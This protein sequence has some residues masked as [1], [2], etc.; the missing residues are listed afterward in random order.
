MLK[1]WSFLLVA[2]LALVVAMASCTAE[3]QIVE[4]TRVVTETEVV[5][6]EVPGEGSETVVEV[7]VE[8][9]REVEVVVTEV[10]TE[11]VEVE[12]SPDEEARNGGWLD[13]I[14]FVRE[15]DQNAAVARLL[16]GDIDMY[17]SG[18]TVAAAQASAASADSIQTTTQYGLYYEIFFNVGACTDET[19]LNPFTNAKIRE[20]MNWAIDRDYVADEIYGGTAVPKYTAFS[21]AGVDRAN[22]ATEIRAM[23]T[24]YAYNLEAAREVII[25]EMEG[26]GATLVDG[27]WNYNDAPVNL[28]FLIRNGGGPRTVK[29]N[30][31]A[32]QLEELGFQVERR[33]GS[34]SDLSPLW[35]QGDPTACLWHAYTGGWSQTAIARDDAGSFNQF[36]LPEGYP[37]PAWQVFDVPQEMSDIINRLVN[38]D[39]AD[40]EERAELF[41]E[42]L[43][44]TLEQSYRVWV[45]S[46]ITPIPYND[47]VQ[48]TSDLAAGIQGATLWAR[49]VRFTDEVGG[50]MTVGIE[51][52]FVEPWN[53]IGGSNWVF[54]A[55]VKNAI[56]EPA[57]YPDPNL[58]IAFPNRV[59]S[60]AIEVVEGTPIGKNEGSDWVE[61]T[62]VPEIAV[63]DDAWVAWDAENQVFLTASEVYTEPTRAV[64]KSTVT[65]PAGFDGVTWHDGSPVTAADLVLAMITRFDLANEA[66]PY[67][68][69]AAVPVFEQFISTFKGVRIVSVDPLVIETY[70]DNPGLDAENAVVTW[71]PYS[72]YAYS[73]AAFQNMSLLLRLEEQGTA[74]FTPEKSTELTVERVSL[75][76]G[77]SLALIAGELISAQVEGF[78]P[79]APT[80]GEFITADEAVA[81]YTNLAEFARRYGHY[82]IGTGVYFLQ[83]VFPVEKQAVLSHYAAHPDSADRFANFAAPP[84]ATV[85]VEGDSQVT[86]GGEATFDIY[87]DYSMG[88][89]PMDDI[90]SVTYLLFD[91][92]GVQV[93]TGQ[94]EAV[95]DGLW[96]VALDGA[97][98]ELLGE[99]SSRIEVVVVSKLTALPALGSYQFV[100]TP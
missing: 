84:N 14:S 15:P 18:L 1:K 28:I 51:N 30:Y 82:Y 80:L 8:V 57:V 7:E 52:M 69:A 68:D 86:I 60:A 77:P 10:V 54:D 89:Y 79:Y 20:A 83:G 25:A 76:S 72:T 62:F 33:E 40:L 70:A 50:S 5:E 46:Q 19:V 37:I 39:Y 16:A 85:D 56:S 17:P 11:T 94:A 4:V 6:V 12:A 61:L 49:T 93:A 98:T 100:T 66:S 65:Y 75:L 24:K 71:W 3:P 45:V 26:M 96:E 97:T 29:G 36:Y 59:E 41:R 78:I 9:T 53:P 34:A 42:V 21:E 81:R 87:V 63:P 58:G 55:V 88:A 47:N 48:V 38:N 92:N 43:P 91:A 32:S 35:V 23:E 22:F 13:T 64:Y 2:M 90:A 31:V 74:V 95:E 99:G 44:M 73:D 67:Y 27:V